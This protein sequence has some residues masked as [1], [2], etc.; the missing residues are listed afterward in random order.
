MDKT[1]S[2]L[3]VA[4]ILFCFCVGFIIYTG[5]L[6]DKVKEL[7]NKIKK[8]EET[9]VIRTGFITGYGE[10]KIITM[11]GGRMWYHYHYNTSKNWAVE[12]EGPVDYA[13]LDRI[14]ALTKLADYVKMS[15]TLFSNR[16]TID[17]ER[18][19][20]EKAGFEVKFEKEK[21]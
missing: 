5:A 9:Y 21:E 14:S 7:S 13:L 16:S 11:D 2:F 17:K 6:R 1:T 10:Y 15:G 12:I 4:M 8:L 3:V 19:M 18:E 20:L